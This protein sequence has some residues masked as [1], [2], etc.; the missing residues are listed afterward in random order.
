MIMYM[1]FKGNEL[2]WARNFRVKNE[3]DYNSQKS[4]NRKAKVI[5]Y[6][7]ALYLQSYDT[8]VAKIENG[9]YKIYGWYSETTKRHINDFLM[10]NGFEALNKKEMMEVI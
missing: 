7:G 9:E 4:F 6:N 10:Q 5:E 1:I 8:I 2:I 3:T